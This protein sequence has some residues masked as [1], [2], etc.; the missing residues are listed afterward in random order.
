MILLFN[1]KQAKKAK[2]QAKKAKKQVKKKVKRRRYLTHQE[3]LQRKKRKLIS[4]VWRN[5]RERR[6]K[7][8][9]LRMWRNELK[10]KQ[11]WKNKCV[12]SYCLWHQRMFAVLP[13]KKISRSIITKAYY[14]TKSLNVVFFGS[15]TVSNPTLQLL[16]ND[17]LREDG[18]INKLE[19]FNI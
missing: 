17:Y 10:S 2:K 11:E 14:S 9:F 4:K 7:R 15:D 1:L 12:F 18:L 16:Y 19:V 13:L 5:R 3:M 8:R 6:E